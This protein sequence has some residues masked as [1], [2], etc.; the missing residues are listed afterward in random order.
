MKL[1]MRK[2]EE[3]AA[4]KEE[5]Q[6]KREQEREQEKERREQGQ[7]RKEMKEKEL[8]KNVEEAPKAGLRAITSEV[9]C[10]PE[11]DEMDSVSMEDYSRRLDQATKLIK[12]IERARMVVNHHKDNIRRG[13]TLGYIASGVGGAEGEDGR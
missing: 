2:L 12:D 8:G 11:M 3:K 13:A 10:V 5:E 4:R 6:E 9:G 1:K 7:E